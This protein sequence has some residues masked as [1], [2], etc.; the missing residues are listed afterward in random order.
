M[1]RVRFLLASLLIVAVLSYASFNTVYRFT[2]SLVW[3]V[4]TNECSKQ[5]AMQILL[6]LLIKVLF[7]FV[8]FSSCM[9]VFR[10]PDEICATNWMASQFCTDC[11]GVEWASY[12]IGIFL[13][14]RCASVHRNIGAHISKVKHL[15]MDRW[16]DSEIER[17]KEVGNFKARQ[18]YEQRVPAC[19]RRPREHDPQWVF[20]TTFYTL[21]QL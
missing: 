3:L 16:E 12:N 21:L 1:G 4:W 18:K 9:I 2:F 10:R 19:Y 17:M 15:K 7:L 6:I 5:R 14:T 20:A 13:C 8:F 11:I